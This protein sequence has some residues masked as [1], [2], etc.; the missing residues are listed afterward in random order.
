MYKWTD[1]R[2]NVARKDTQIAEREHELDQAC[3]E[4]ERAT[5]EAGVAAKDLV[6]VQTPSRLKKG[7]KVTRTE[8]EVKEVEMVVTKLRTQAGVKDGT[9]KN[10]EAVGGIR[11]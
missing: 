6:D 10:E 9:I 3:C 11:A 7:G 2:A 5:R 8:E 4:K 1:H